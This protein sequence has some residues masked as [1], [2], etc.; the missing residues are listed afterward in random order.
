MLLGD[1]LESILL[2]DLD[3]FDHRAVDGVADR[4]AELGLR[5]LAQGNA[6]EWH[7]DSMAVRRARFVQCSSFSPSRG[8]PMNS[9][10][11]SPFA[12][13]P[14]QTTCAALLIPSQRGEKPTAGSPPG[15]VSDC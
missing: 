4:A 5:A 15:A 1:D 10:T 14:P 9:P 8:V 11:V 2:G 3:R 12:S 7:V 13:L 6:D